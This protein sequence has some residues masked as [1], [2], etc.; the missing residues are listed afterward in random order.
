MGKDTRPKGKLVR[1]FGENI[2]EMPKFDKLLAKR[3]FPAGQHGVQR[4]RAKLSGYAKQ[5]REK[6][7]VKLIYGIK[8]RQFSNY[9]AEASTKTGDT[10]QFLL[11]YLEGRLDNVI[12]RAGFAK[13]RP[14]ARQIV[15]HGQILVNGKKVDIASYR[16]RV[17][18]IITLKDAA[19]KSKL[20][21]GVG[22]VMA[23]K[24]GPG[25]LALDVKAL[26]A[27]VVNAPMLEHPNFDTNV[28]IGF[29][30]R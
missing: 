4:K 25:W 28:I 20:F 12:F 29:Y 8:E 14:A 6:Q 13:S 16:V 24:D 1:L 10:S 23:K 27:K 17:G 19:K 3:N 18:E 21:E 2:F 9:V 30:S 26:T 22:E 7:K 11:G 5:L 15:A